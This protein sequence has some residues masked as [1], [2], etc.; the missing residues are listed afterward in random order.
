MRAY[1]ACGIGV[2]LASGPAFSQSTPVPEEARA[3]AAAPAISTDVVQRTSGTLTVRA[4]RIRE[5]IAMDGRLDDSVYTEVQPVSDFIQQ[6]PVEGAPATEK[7][8]AWVLFDDENLYIACRCW[9]THPERIVA[10]DMR[11]DSSN[12]RQ[13]DNFGVGLDTFHDKRNGYL[14]SVSPVRMDR[15][16]S[17]QSLMSFWEMIRNSASWRARRS[18]IGID[19]ARAMVAPTDAVS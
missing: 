16:W 7:T 8:E 17:G 14:F 11:R 19:S 15:K 4:T 9:D 10:N 3:S 5:P 18:S 2:L 12:L 6:E 13:Q 1:L